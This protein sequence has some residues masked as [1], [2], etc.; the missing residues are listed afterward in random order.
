VERTW[1]IGEVAERTGLTRRTLRHYDDLGL[2]V[3]S[4]RSWSDYRL[5]TEDD[6]LR[7]LQIQNLKALGLSL[8]EIADA[9]ADP[10]L[11]AGATLR[12]HLGH[13]EEQ[14]AAEQRLA[15]RL[16]RLAGTSERSWDEVLD[17]IAATGRL[18]HFDPTVRLRTALQARGS[19]LE[20]LDALAVERD[21][22][23][24]EVLIWSLTRQPDATSAALARLDNADPDLRCLLVRLLGK[25]S[26]AASVPALLPLLADADPRVVG[27]TVRALTSIGDPAA[28]SALV[29]LLG[30]PDVAE[31]DLLDA[32]VATGPAAVGPLAS[33]ADT[34][35]P[36]VRAA[37]AEALGRLKVDP[38]GKDAGRIRTVLTE[39][40]AD[41]DPDVRLAALL[42]LSERGAA[43]RPTIEAALD[44]PVLAPLARRL[45]DPHVT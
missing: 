45:L 1:R 32:I 21:P 20:L 31:A 30:R 39:R 41:P 35:R 8:A 44:D 10:D 40:L 14:I 43:E 38:S 34:G 9:L 26:D 15:D 6:L 29:A 37:A 7:L 5:Y 22:A 36:D 33:A 11:D 24:Q 27:S 19:T 23:V 17:A 42:A 4:E 2:L 3:P 18:A 13:L 25:T 16:H 12:S 28:A